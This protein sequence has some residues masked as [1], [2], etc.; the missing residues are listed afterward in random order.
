M[1]F[2]TAAFFVP[3]SEE[4]R[5]LLRVLLSCLCNYFSNFFTLYHVRAIK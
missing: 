2:K 3:R 1:T 4:L 5:S